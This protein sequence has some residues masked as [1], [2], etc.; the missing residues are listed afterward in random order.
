VSVAE[1]I[2][3]LCG[4]NR[5]PRVVFKYYFCIII[6]RPRNAPPSAHAA[7]FAHSNVVCGDGMGR[8]HNANPKDDY[9]KCNQCKIALTRSNIGSVD[10]C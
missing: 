8:D 2:S 6:T 7:A 5:A 10:I 1:V 4:L 3:A 9:A